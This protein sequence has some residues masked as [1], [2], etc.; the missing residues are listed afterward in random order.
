M[1][2]VLSRRA[3]ST[4]RSPSIATPRESSPAPSFAARCAVSVHVPPIFSNR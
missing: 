2:I 1:P 4:T 3:P